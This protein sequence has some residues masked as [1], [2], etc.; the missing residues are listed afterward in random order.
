MAAP[1][2]RKVSQEQGH[3]EELVGLGGQLCLSQEAPPFVFLSQREL[4]RHFC[5]ANQ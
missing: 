2:T 3:L 5:L 1:G 4:R